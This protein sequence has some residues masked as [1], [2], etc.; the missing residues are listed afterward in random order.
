MSLENDAMALHKEFEGLEIPK[1]KTISREK[2]M[3]LRKVREG[4]L[5]FTDGKEI[6]TS[7]ELR[8]TKE[9]D[10][11]YVVGDGKLIPVDSE[12]EGQ[13]IINKLKNSKNESQLYKDLRRQKL[14]GHLRS[15][16]KKQ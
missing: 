6:D 7:G 13:E 8:I 11:L 4:K 14:R 2:L 3:E 15:R 1:K 9:D 10:G 5:R 16:A 12:E